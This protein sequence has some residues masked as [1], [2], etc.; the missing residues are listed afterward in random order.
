MHFER[1]VKNKKTEVTELEL[2]SKDANHARDLAKNEL[3]RLEQQIAEERKQR[4]KELQTKRDLVRQRRE[5]SSF[6]DRLPKTDNNVEE[7][8]SEEKS[9]ETLKI[10]NNDPEKDK[11]L[12]EYEEVMRLIKDAMGVSNIHEVLQKFEEQQATK[13]QL[14][15]LKDETE[16][17]LHHLKEKKQETLK[18]FDEIKIASEEKMNHCKRTITEFQEHIKENSVKL[19]ETKSKYD[20]VKN[21]L[22]DLKTGIKY[23]VD[24]LEN[25]PSAVPVASTFDE[26]DV[27]GM[28]ELC[29]NKLEEIYSHV[30]EKET[31]EVLK[32]K[33]SSI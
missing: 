32:I 19:L 23:L 1:T 18:Q 3:S 5:E 14:V 7:F 16:R 28:L 17:N 30:K 6:L 13:A 8:A 2:L 4:E 27:F 26:S 20:K 12:R 21:V 15:H 10:D 33:L 25:A 11:R 22:A 9:D 29:S 24:R 31:I